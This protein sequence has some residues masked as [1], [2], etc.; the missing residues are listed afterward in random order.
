MKVFHSKADLSLPGNGCSVAIGNFDGVHLGHQALLQ[1][2]LQQARL[3]GAAPTVL[4]F[5]P[6]P[7]EVLH[8]SKKLM[9]L[10]TTAEK[11]ELLE[12]LG[13]ELVFV[14]PF[15]P[16]LASLDAQDFFSQYL[17][18]GLKAKSVHV[19]TGF[20]F[21]KGRTGDTGLLATWCR[22]SGILFEAMPAFKLGEDRV[23]SSVIREQV[24][25]GEVEA[26]ARN[27]GRP[28]YLKGKVVRGDGRGRQL[29]FPTANVSIA[30]EKILPKNGVYTATATWQR[31]TF[32]AVVNV[33]LRP[34]FDQ[35]ATKPLVE[36]HFLDFDANLY[37]EEVTICFRLRLRD[38][39]KFQSIDELKSQIHHDIAATRTTR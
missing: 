31:Q 14:A 16:E 20:R 36:A 12:S 26:A 10:T 9:R 8:P 19:G 2:M 4:T 38:E 21:G 27:L 34:T 29:G 13:V 25:N 18:E 15:T 3:L 1:S 30:L 23:S 32:T 39:K 11:L 5:Y 22:E 17:R 35:A 24:M 28:F 7:V 33:G 6:H 37:D